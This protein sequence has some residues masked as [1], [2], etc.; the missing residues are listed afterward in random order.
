[1]SDTTDACKAWQHAKRA[2][3]TAVPWTADW[4]RLRMIEED[5]RA[6][7]M[8]SLDAEADTPVG[9]EGLAALGGERRIAGRGPEP[10]R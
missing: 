9:R 5:R 2:L 3:Q 1:M 8:A 10:G 4:Q 7:F 6:A